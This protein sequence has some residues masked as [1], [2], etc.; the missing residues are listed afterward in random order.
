MNQL[1]SKWE[2]RVDRLLPLLPRVPY[3]ASNCQHYAAL[4]IPAEVDIHVQADHDPAFGRRVVDIFVELCLPLPAE[5][6]EPELLRTYSHLRFGNPDPEVQTALALEANQNLR[7]I[8]VRCLLLLPEYTYCEIA[9]RADLTEGAV[10][11]YHALH[12]AVRDQ[13]GSVRWCSPR[14]GNVNCV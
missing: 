5:V 7:R 14:A 10:R 1:G 12:W 9:K 13:S 11:I 3:L 2:D 4:G 6:E 8:L